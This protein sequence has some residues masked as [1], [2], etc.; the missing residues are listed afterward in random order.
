MAIL[1]WGIND[2]GYKVSDTS[3]GWVCP[4]YSK[5][6]S[7]IHRVKGKN[8]N[9]KKTYENCSISEDFRYLSQFTEWSKSQGF[10]EEFSHLVHLDKDSL[11]TG[12][13]EYSQI[14]CCFLPAIVNCNLADISHGGEYP[15][16]IIKRKRRDGSTFLSTGLVHKK[17]IKCLGVV[18]DPMEG[19]RL[20][21]KEKIKILKDLIGDYREFCLGTGIKH[22]HQVEER[23]LNK[24]NGIQQDYDNK[25][26]TIPSKSL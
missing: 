18:S 11:V 24:A 7:M 16:G 2:V 8:L 15:L 17:K 23:I 1:G 6:R 13:T 12:N 3:T 22:Y 25:V 14:S 20:W 21:Q 4:F 26:E 10:G 9:H 19:H 5:W